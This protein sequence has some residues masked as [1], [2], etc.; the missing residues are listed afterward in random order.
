[1]SQRRHVLGQRRAG[2]APGRCRRSSRIWLTASRTSVSS[3]SRQRVGSGCTCSLR[4][5]SV[6]WPA[7][8]RFRLS[9]V[10]WWP[11]RSCSSR[12]M[13]GALVHPRA[14]RQQ[15]AGGAQFG[16]EPALLLA[17]LRLL[18]RDQAGDEDEA[19]RSRR[20]AP[21]ASARPAG[22]KPR[23]RTN[24]GTT[25]ELAAAI[26][27]A[28]PSGSGSSHGSTQAT[29]I[30]RMLPRP[31]AGVVAD[32]HRRQRQHAPAAAYVDQRCAAR[33]PGRGSASQ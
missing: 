5:P 8:S 11:S 33:C 2:R 12:E 7:T 26:S 20:T 1:M 32:R 4:R 16:V 9:A 18:P 31:R 19:R 22:V 10:R 29:T 24:T 28:T 13:R 17:R 21:T 6:R 30:S 3:S 23:P 25:R 14:F 15:R 27:Q